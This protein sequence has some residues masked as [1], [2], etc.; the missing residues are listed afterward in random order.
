MLT[1]KLLL[2]A[3]YDS[4]VNVAIS[5]RCGKLYDFWRVFTYAQTHVEH[6]CGTSD[7]HT[8]RGWPEN[9]TVMLDDV[10]LCC[11]PD[12]PSVLKGISSGAFSGEI[13]AYC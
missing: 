3:D 4:A 7:L 5:W 1:N 9:N 10:C 2:P 12:G 8:P 6:I 11:Y 13:M